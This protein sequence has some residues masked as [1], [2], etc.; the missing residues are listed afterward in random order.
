MLTSIKTLEHLSAFSGTLKKNATTILPDALKNSLYS[1]TPLYPHL[2]K[3]ILQET[4]SFFKQD[5]IIQEIPTIMQIQL[6]NNTILGLFGEDHLNNFQ[7]SIFT[8]GSPDIILFFEEIQHE[9]DTMLYFFS[10]AEKFDCYKE[11]N[12]F[13][14]NYVIPAQDNKAISY[15]F[16]TF[17][18]IINSIARK[19]NLYL[20]GKQMN[21][22]NPNDSYDISNLLNVIY[23]D[24]NDENHY[25]V[26]TFIKLRIILEKLAI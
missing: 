22:E 2:F 19:I 3:L 23:A 17:C 1:A 14:T 5:C 15:T 4:C 18:N 16:N 21:L 26:V 12:N 6:V 9:N 11:L 7:R 8:C 25:L 10:L 13:L 24:P 20:K